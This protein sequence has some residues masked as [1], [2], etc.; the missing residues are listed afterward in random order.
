MSS[1]A[2]AEGRSHG[3]PADYAGMNDLYDFLPEKVPQLA[4]PWRHL[5]SCFYVAYRTLT[6]VTAPCVFDKNFPVKAS[7]LAWVAEG[8]VVTSAEPTVVGIAGS[9]TPS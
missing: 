9:G 4:L 7:S 2:G 6:T 3:G 5:W 1:L 8:V